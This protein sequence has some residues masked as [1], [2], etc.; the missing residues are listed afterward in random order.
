M[1]PCTRDHS[2]APTRVP[3]RPPL[4]AMNN[5]RVATNANSDNSDS[6]GLRSHN[7]NNN[8]KLMS[9]VDEANG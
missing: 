8:D 1:V 2:S 9:A 3:R 5:M 7:S 4:D 6:N